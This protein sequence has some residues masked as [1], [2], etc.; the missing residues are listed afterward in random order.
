[1]AYKPA[2]GQRLN[3]P[4]GANTDTWKLLAHFQFV[5]FYFKAQYPESVLQTTSQK[6][7]TQVMKLVNYNKIDK[8]YLLRRCCTE[9]SSSYNI[10]RPITNLAP[11]WYSTV[12][13]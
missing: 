11:C 1:M 3:M 13:Y 2:S 5:A 7:C 9:T 12:I 4:L 8:I 10:Q 6:V